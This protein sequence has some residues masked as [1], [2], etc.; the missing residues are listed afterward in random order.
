MHKAA[1][2]LSVDKEKNDET[3]LYLSLIHIWDSEPEEETEPE[4][5]TDLEEETKTEEPTE[6]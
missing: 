6:W 1:S 4:R 5:E 2:A 3:F